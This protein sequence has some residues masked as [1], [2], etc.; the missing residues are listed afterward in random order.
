MAERGDLAHALKLVKKFDMDSAKFLVAEIVNMLEYLHNIGVGHR[1][2]KPDN[3]FITSTGHL[4]LVRTPIKLTCPRVTLEL[5]TSPTRLVDS[6]RWRTTNKT[7]IRVKLIKIKRKIALLWALKITCL[8]KSCSQMEQQSMETSGRLV[9]SSTNF[10]VE[11]LLLAA[12]T[13][14]KCFRRS[15]MSSMT[16]QTTYQK[17]LKI[18]FQKCW[19]RIP[20]QD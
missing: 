1:D 7:V 18:W 16:F 2:L 10:S 14:L 12:S 11:K 9:W 17:S 4:K 13:N 8:Q 5:L 20:I 15:S 6:W 19:S 3:L